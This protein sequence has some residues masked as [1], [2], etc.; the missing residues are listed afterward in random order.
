MSDGSLCGRIVDVEFNPSCYE[1]TAVCIK[2]KQNLL[3][4]CLSL[5]Q[6]ERVLV[7][8]VGKI[9]QIGKDVVFIELSSEKR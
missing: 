4:S 6:K 7:V 9:V 3:Q 5:F 1:I 8:D 2:E